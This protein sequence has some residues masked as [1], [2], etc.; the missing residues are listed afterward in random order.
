MLL[1]MCPLALCQTGRVGAKTTRTSAMLFQKLQRCF[2][3]FSI[4]SY[5]L[6]NIIYSYS[7]FRKHAPFMWKA[8]RTEQGFKR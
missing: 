4:I 6:N 1:R 2:D 8:V 3:K 7:C 5:I